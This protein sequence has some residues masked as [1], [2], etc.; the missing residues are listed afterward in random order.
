VA[1]LKALVLLAAGMV[2]AFVVIFLLYFL[3][4]SFRPDQTYASS[5]CLS[6]REFESVAR[7]RGASAGEAEAMCNERVPKTK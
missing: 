2:G 1:P 7:R 5:V 4:E 6:I 3:I